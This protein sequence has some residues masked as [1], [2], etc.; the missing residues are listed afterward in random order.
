VNFLARG[1]SAVLSL[2]LVPV[3][4][5]FLGIESYGLLG[6][7]VALQA[8]L[9]IFDLGIGATINREMARVSD[10]SL[11]G[12]KVV[13]LV[14]TTEILSW[15]VG[16]SIALVIW[17]LGPWVSDHWLRRENFDQE[18][19][20]TAISIFSLVVLCQWP[21]SFYRNGLMGLQEQVICNL[22]TVLFSIIQ[23]LGAIVVLSMYSST[24]WALL[25]WQACANGLHTAVL[26]RL[27]WSKLPSSAGK[28]RFCLESLRPTVGFAASMSLTSVAVI[29]LGQIDK[30]LLGRLL[31]LDAFGHYIL[32]TT[33]ASALALPAA[34]ITDAVLPKY[35]QLVQH[36]EESMLK[37][38]F[39]RACQTTAWLVFPLAAM[40]I[41]FSTEIV[42]LWT[43]V[44]G[45]ASRS[46]VV[47]SLLT[48]GAAL[49]T[50]MSSLDLLQMAHGWLKPAMISRLIAICVLVPCLFLFVAKAGL[51]GAGL[52][53]L[54]VYVGYVT[55][56][57]HFVWRRL[58]KGEMGRWYLSDMV[59][60]FVV[61]CGTA[62]LW[63]VG[64]SIPSGRIPLFLFLLCSWMVIS[65]VVIGCLPYVRREMTH[66]LKSAFRKETSALLI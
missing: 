37:A 65:L 45:L 43:G 36:G 40:L 2:L 16:S 59:I 24:I 53:W 9:G 52:A 29:L 15:L 47:V 17:T 51:E 64:F 44:E 56:T 63:R 62:A 46:A 38:T 20:R 18:V 1:L 50:M 41:V 12:Q 32:A 60:P 7:L 23:G 55:I 30:M 58:L 26:K 33:I 8:T 3:Y 57:P 42:F 39:H 13:E 31:P 48:L 35:I 22:A 66:L 61:A 25:L 28:P 11:K 19:I 54:V 34:P 14:R 6:F 5:S 21:Q 27:L 49:N 10:M 4:I